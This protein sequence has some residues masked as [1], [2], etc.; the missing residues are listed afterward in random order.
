MIRRILR[1]FDSWVFDGYRT[2]SA[3]LG[4]Y[5]IVYSM[6]LLISYVPCCQWAQSAPSAFF[7]PPLGPAA[8]FTSLPPPW[9]LTALNILLAVSASLLLVGYYTRFAS[10]ASGFLLLSINLWGYS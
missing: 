3:D 9:E 1:R 2:R 5:R 6:F 10:L 4:F 8:L 7:K